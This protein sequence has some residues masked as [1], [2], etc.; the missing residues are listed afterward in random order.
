[1]RQARI[2]GVRLEVFELLARSLMTGTKPV[3]TMLDVVRSLVRFLAGLPQYTRN[4]SNLPEETIRVREALLRARE[5]ALLL[6]ADL[7]IACG[8]VAFDAGGQINHDE[9]Q[10][11][12]LALKR[13]L[14][15]LQGAYPQLLS[16]LEQ[17]VRHAFGLPIP[18]AHLRTELRARASRVL[19]LAV[20]PLLRG[21]LVRA[22]D[23]TLEHEEWIVSLATYLASRPPGEWFDR[24][25]EQFNLQLG[26][27]SRRFRSLEAMAIAESAADGGTRLVRIAVA[28]QGSIEQESVVAIREDDMQLLALLKERILGTVHR[29][30]PDVSRDTIV[31]AL[32]LVTERLLS[33]DESRRIR[34]EAMH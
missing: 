11:F 4:T 10:R 9:V 7:P 5:A 20:E 6:F 15:V 30:S 3:K 29:V 21:F 2:S 28:T 31:A 34:E 27:V 32:A 18:G 24:D 12:F 13:N 16:E 33:E 22:D 25:R 17:L 19:P 1:V 26:V 23:E 14:G 8:C